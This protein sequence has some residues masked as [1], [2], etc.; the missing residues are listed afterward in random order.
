MA[1]HK[2]LSLV[3]PKELSRTS[4]IDAS[5]QLLIQSLQDFSYFRRS[6]FLLRLPIS[7]SDEI[8]FPKLT[9]GSLIFESPRKKG[10]SVS[11]KHIVSGLERILH[12]DGQSKYGIAKFTN[13]WCEDAPLF[14]VHFTSENALEKFLESVGN[15]LPRPGI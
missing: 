1:T 5:S 14:E 15:F 10:V 8:C 7:I 9:E 2:N 13:Y 12:A 4:E 11:F 3:N 6:F